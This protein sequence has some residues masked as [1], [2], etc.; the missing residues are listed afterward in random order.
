MAAAAAIWLYTLLRGQA[1]NT[2]RQLTQRPQSL[3]YILGGAVFGPLIG[4]SLS[5]LAVQRT[6]VGIASTLIALTPIF[7]LPIGALVFKERFGWQAVAGTLLA[8]LGVGLLFL[9]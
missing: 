7:M 8:I 3:P 6:E 5:L 1:G 9:S 2:L 4:V